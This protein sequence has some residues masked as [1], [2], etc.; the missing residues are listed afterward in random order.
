MNEV[1][2][3][4]DYKVATSTPP[5][6]STSPVPPANCNGSMANRSGGL[7]NCTAVLPHILPENYTRWP[8]P[9]GKLNKGPLHAGNYT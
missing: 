7:L 4:V 8:L 6:E 3:A 1:W 5:G 2:L 9:T